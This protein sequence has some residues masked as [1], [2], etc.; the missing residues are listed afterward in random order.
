MNLFATVAKAWDITDNLI[1][2][3][4]EKQDE[5]LAKKAEKI[6]IDTSKSRA[7]DHNK[8]F[9]HQKI[10]DALQNLLANTLPDDT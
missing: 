4:L 8:V 3:S 2:L 1:I 5:H 6:V 7:S 9:V 10:L